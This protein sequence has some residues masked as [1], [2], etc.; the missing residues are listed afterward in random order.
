MSDTYTLANQA[1]KEKG[2]ADAA[3]LRT[4][5]ADLDGTAVIAEES[6]VPDFVAGKDYSAWP[7][8]APVTD[9]GQVYK[10]LQ[11]YDAASWPD[12]R[13]ADLPALWSICHTKDPLKAK[14]W[15]APNGTSGMY[16]LDECCTEGGHV[17]KST[18]DDNVWA[19]SGYPQGWTDLGTVGEMENDQCAEVETA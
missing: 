2:T 18:M 15:Q 7:V 3:D 1:M 17:W 9:G 14:P 11:P 12:Q 13:P 10:L 6:K 8:G 16:M 4:R 5:A 19:P